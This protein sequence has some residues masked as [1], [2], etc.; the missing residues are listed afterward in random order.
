MPYQR[1]LSIALLLP[2]KVHFDVSKFIKQENFFPIWKE[3]FEHGRIT[4][5]VPNLPSSDY[6]CFVFGRFRVQISTQT[7]LRV[8]AVFLSTSIYMPGQYLELRHERFLL[9][10]FYSSY[11]FFFGTPPFDAMQSDSI[12]P[13]MN[14]RTLYDH[15]KQNP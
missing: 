12:L 8:F 10:L 2:G 7:T 6:H 1:F 15:D 14:L 5:V 3:I 9:N 13:L 11:Y 4:N